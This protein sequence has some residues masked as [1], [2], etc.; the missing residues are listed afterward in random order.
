MLKAGKR[1][2]AEHAV[3]AACT[4]AQLWYSQ[5]DAF[6][7]RVNLGSVV[8]FRHPAIVSEQDCVMQFAR[9]LN[10]SGVPW[11][12][13]HHQLSASR[14]F[15]ETPHPAATAGA[16]RWRVDLALLSCEE[17]MAA[18][19]PAREPGFQFDVFLEFAYLGDS[20]AQEGSAAWGEPAK[21]IRKVEA[22]VKKIGHYLEARACRRGYVIAFE[23]CDYGFGHDFAANTEAE[24]GC[25]VR[26]VW[27]Y[28]R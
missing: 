11:G 16:K 1:G 6:P 10:E 22:D 8:G 27:G 4:G 2:W 7:R 21:G 23:E 5:L 18:N 14:W 17:F 25:Q 15:F 19:L 26:F 24:S 12:A 20:W 28:E 9:F 3:E 13:I